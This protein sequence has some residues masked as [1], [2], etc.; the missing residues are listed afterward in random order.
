MSKYS[1]NLKELES[2]KKDYWFEEI[3]DHKLNFLYLKNKKNSY[4]FIRTFL[5]KNYWNCTRSAG[6]LND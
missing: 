3:Q 1:K 6:L 2:E 4:F 5:L